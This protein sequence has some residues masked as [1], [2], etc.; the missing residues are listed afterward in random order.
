LRRLPS[1]RLWNR[2]V[3]KNTSSRQDGFSA[4]PDYE[5][6]LGREGVSITQLRPGGVA[7]IDGEKFDVLTYGEF[8]EPGRKLVVVKA[9][10]SKLFVRPLEDKMPS[11][12]I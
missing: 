5:I 10:G 9:E 7:E 12:T 3:L 4:G 2:F 1:S 8:V 6:F 11:G